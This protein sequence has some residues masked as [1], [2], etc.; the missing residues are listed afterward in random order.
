MN[1][2]FTTTK[3][4]A[5]SVAV[6]SAW[7]VPALAEG[8]LKVGKA[9]IIRNEVVNLGEA[10]LIPIKVGDEVVRDETVRTSADSAARFGL[11]DETKLTLGPSSTLKIDRAV[12]ADD[13][14][15]KQITIRLT[16]GVF[17]FITGNSDKK[18]Y[19]IETPSA[20]IGVRGTILD[21]RISEDRTSVVLQDGKASVCAGSKCTQL[22]ER[23]NTAHVTRE[24][25]VTQIK[26]DLV[27]TWT[28][29]SVCSGNSALCSPLPALKKA[30]LAVPPQAGKALKKTATTK[31][32][33]DGQPMVGSSCGQSTNPFRDATLPQIGDTSKDL[34]ILSSPSSYPSLPTNPSISPAS[35]RLSTPL[36]RR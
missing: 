11:I 30:N 14:R 31:F 23:G 8:A 4:L 25:N 2:F 34:P 5:V 10:Q 29:A 13:T 18:S 6:I 16:E 35:P 24:G 17:R 21:I 26:R 15:Y 19:K 27:P 32:C 9:E 28:F 36:L 12:Y 33:P 22:L 1:L 7:Y 3:C 20:T